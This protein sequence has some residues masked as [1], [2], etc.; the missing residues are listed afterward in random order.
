M[1]H[2]CFLK[3]IFSVCVSCTGKNEFDVPEEPKIIDPPI[4]PFDP[5]PGEMDIPDPVEIIFDAQSTTLTNPF[6]NANDPAVNIQTKRKTTVTFVDGS[7]NRLVGGMGFISSEE[8]D[9]KVKAAFFSRGQFV[10]EGEGSLTV[11]SRYRHAICS[12]DYIR[13]NEG[14]ITIPISANDGLHANDY[15][16]INGG[17][18]EINAMG[19]GM[20][21]EGYIQ[22]NGGSIAIT[23]TSDKSHGIKSATETTVQSS[24]NIEIH[25]EGDASKA[26]KSKGKMLI[27]KGNLHLT[28]T[29]NACY[30]AEEADMSSAS[31]IKCN[32]GVGSALSKK[33]FNSSKMFWITGGSV[34]GTGG[35][36][37][38]PA[39]I[40]CTQYVVDYTGNIMRN[41]NFNISSSAGK[42]ILTYQLPC[43]LSKAFVLFSSP[44]L[45]RNE[46]YTVSSGGTVTGGESFHGLFNEAT[47]SGG[48]N[49]ATFTVSS[50]ITNIN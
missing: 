35:A 42:N 39:A 25:L 4:D 21:S 10:F 5:E 8:S 7:T 37:S 3:L 50:M 33:A 12:D 11:I 40:A 48:Y 29:G 43:T 17:T 2:I 45:A 19:D 27:S 47:Y 18:I 9:E 44:D 14:N 23:T 26:F 13:I 30:D 22:I 15:I 36:S 6:I 16:E 28:T 41:A 38:S 32:V 20:D 46:S 34:V 31:G 24:G 49:R 1:R